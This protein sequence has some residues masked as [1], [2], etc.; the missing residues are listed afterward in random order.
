MNE[1]TP[2]DHRPDLGLGEAVQEALTASDDAAFVRRVVA[3][4]PGAQPA[5][6]SR[7]DV[8]GQWAGPGVAAAVVLLAA[9]SFWLA[10]GPAPGSVTALTEEP[11]AA[12]AETLTARTLLA[13][14]TLPEFDAD[15]VLT[16]GPTVR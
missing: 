6:E 8:L 15:V 1:F 12:G 14:R 2:F 4:W 5:S 16:G 7:W 10:R 9:V 13:S 3:R 11:L